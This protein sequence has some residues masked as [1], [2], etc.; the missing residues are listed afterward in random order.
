MAQVIYSIA[1]DRDCSGSAY[2]SFAY[3]PLHIVYTPLIFYS[4]LSVP[5]LWKQSAVACFLFSNALALSAVLKE[6]LL[7][8]KVVTVK[9]TWGILFILIYL[10]I[11]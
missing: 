3:P 2:D 7:C 8:T 11:Y 6:R 4:L 5:P 10:C 1:D 9:D